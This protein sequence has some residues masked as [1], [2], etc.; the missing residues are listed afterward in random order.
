MLNLKIVK[1]KPQLRGEFERTMAVTPSIVERFGLFTIIVLGEVIVGVVQG[2]AAHHH[3]TWYI[4]GRA[5]LGMLIAIGVW[6]LYFDSVSHRM[7]RQEQTAFFSWFYLHL[8]LTMGIAAV[9]AAV[10]NVVEHDSDAIPFGVKWLLIGAIGIALAGISLLNR[11]LDL[12]ETYRKLH[13][14][15]GWA[16]LGAAIVI[17]GLGFLSFPTM[18]FLALTVVLMLAP[19]ITALV[20]WI[21][22]RAGET[23]QQG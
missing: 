19:I 11:T 2:L 3:L 17:A 14:V 4:G 22:M 10:L 20:M 5:A 6:W 18:L 12:P 21:K 13:S 15:V 23:S 8:P 1:K 16:A 7:P 9:G